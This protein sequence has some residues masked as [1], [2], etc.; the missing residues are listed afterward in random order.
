VTGEREGMVL[1]VSRNSWPESDVVN[2]LKV[3]VQ[4]HSEVVPRTHALE[5]ESVGQL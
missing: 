5:A 3:I 1:M 4:R 2:N